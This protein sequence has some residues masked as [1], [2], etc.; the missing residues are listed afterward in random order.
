MKFS[1]AILTFSFNKVHL[2]VSFPPSAA[3]MRWWTGSTLVQMMACRLF[4]AKPLSEPCNA[5]ILSIGP[6]GTNF[7]EIWIAILT[8]SFN[9]ML[10]KV[11]SA[12]WRL[13]CPGRD[14]LRY[15]SSDKMADSIF[16]GI[17]LNENASVV[18][19]ISL[20][21]VFLGF[22]IP[23]NL[24][25]YLNDAVDSKNIFK[26]FNSFRTIRKICWSLLVA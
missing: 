21:F 15:W 18:I 3:C 7:S 20:K 12:R 9:K 4:G 14:E 10:L 22:K 5:G 8:F 1:I 11:S 25:G 2:K 16:K 23:K 26:I 13:F 24:G 17:F 19:W 6:L